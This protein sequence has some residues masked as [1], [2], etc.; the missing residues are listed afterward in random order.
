MPASTSSYTRDQLL[1]VARAW[2]VD[3]VL[4][5]KDRT[6]TVEFPDTEQYDFARAEITVADEKSTGRMTLFEVR[7][8]EPRVRATASGKTSPEP[9]AP[10]S[11][12]S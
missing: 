5:S 4:P 11:A 6:T 7:F 10:R 8:L 1:R 2:G 12:R 9:T 3:V